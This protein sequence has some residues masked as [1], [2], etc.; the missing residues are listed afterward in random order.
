MSQLSKPETP[1][2]IVGKSPFYKILM[3]F[4]SQQNESFVVKES[5]DSCSY[6]KAIVIRHETIAKKSQRIRII[7]GLFEC[8]VVVFTHL[9]HLEQDLFSGLVS[10]V[11]GEIKMGHFH[12]DKKVESHPSLGVVG[13][14]YS[15]VEDVGVDW[16]LLVTY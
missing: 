6:A 14:K 11:M 9:H 8:P 2:I 1:Y 12:F 13:S 4:C 3:F 16:C 5:V 15:S 10:R 7:N